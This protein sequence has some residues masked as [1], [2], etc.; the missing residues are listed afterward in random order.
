MAF[1][2]QLARPERGQVGEHALASV[3]RS[4][5]EVN[6]EVLVKSMSL[7]SLPALQDAVSAMLAADYIHLFGF[8]SSA[9]VA[10]DFYQRLLMLGVTTSIHSDAHVLAAVAANAR[11]DALFFGISCSGLTRDVVEALE[12]TGRH[13]CKRIVITSDRNSPA[14]AAS[15][16]ALIS[17]VRRSPINHETIGT[18]T[19]QLAIVEMV[20][21]ALALQHPDPTALKRRRARRRRDRQETACRRF[22]PTDPAEPAPMTETRA[23]TEALVR[24]ERRPPSHRRKGRQC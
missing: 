16:I 9:P 23:T 10:F 7:V 13:G 4:V 17:A 3:M 14:A 1:G 22:G 20:C 15:D 8:G 6:T 18:R 2:A 11:R 5:I 21:V 12:T 19:S 24:A